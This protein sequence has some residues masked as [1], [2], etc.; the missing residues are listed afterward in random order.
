[1]CLVAQFGKWF[2]RNICFWTNAFDV[3]IGQ[4]SLPLSER[5]YII[6]I[7]YVLKFYRRFTRSYSRKIWGDCH[8]NHLLWNSDGLIGVYDVTHITP[9]NCL[10]FCIQIMA[11]HAKT[12]SPLRKNVLWQ[13]RK[14]WI[15]KGQLILKSTSWATKYSLHLANTTTKTR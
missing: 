12:C 8:D 4:K 11:W 3:N 2:F 1:M 10:D 13:L 14:V 7:F 15:G 6:S 5:F 9:V